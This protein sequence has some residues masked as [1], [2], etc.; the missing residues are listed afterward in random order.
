MPIGLMEKKI[1]RIRRAFVIPLGLDALL[2]LLLTLLSFLSTSPLYE[3]AILV[4][5][6]TAVTVVFGESIERR[7]TI[8]GGLRLKK[9]MREKALEWSDITH[10]GALSLRSR[11][12][13]LLTTKK[14]FHILSN[15]YQDFGALVKDII[16]HLPAERIEIEEEVR[17]QGESPTQ[18]KSDL[19][20]AW[21]AAIVLLSIIGF[22]MFS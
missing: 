5:L 16:Y 8:N 15:A 19:F 6:S 22:K 7:V 4:L 18:N 20:A 12:Y 21:L 2:L 14:G 10:V 9:F 17:R 13:V 3:R 1:Y 11:V